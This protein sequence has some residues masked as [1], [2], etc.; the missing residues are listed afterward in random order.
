MYTLLKSATTDDDIVWNFA[1]YFLID[2]VNNT[3]TRHNKI[4][5]IDLDSQI[6]SV[7]DASPSL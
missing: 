1:T 6:A 5:P 2:R 3:V 4:N 7:V